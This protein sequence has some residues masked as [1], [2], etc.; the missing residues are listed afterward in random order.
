[1]AAWHGLLFREELRHSPYRSFTLL[2]LAGAVFL[3][4]P[5]AAWGVRE[6]LALAGEEG[7]DPADVSVLPL[8]YAVFLVWVLGAGLK[9]RT[10]W[11]VIR[12]SPVPRAVLGLDRA[13]GVFLVALIVAGPY[14]WGAVQG[15][16]FQPAAL[17][18]LIALPLWLSARLR[19][20]G[21]LW[22][23]FM[24]LLSA[25]MGWSM[26]FLVAK[27]LD[28][29][30]VFEDYNYEMARQLLRP[31]FARL[32]L[33]E[34]LL[35]ALRAPAAVHVLVGLGAL[36]G[37]AS[38]LGERSDDTNVFGFVGT[39]LARWR[40]A[41]AALAMSSLLR[42]LDVGLSQAVMAGAFALAARTYGLAA[43]PPG[44]V[45]W[46]AVAAL[47]WPVWKERPALPAALA[48]NAPDPRRV[49]VELVSGRHRAL[50]ATLVPFLLLPGAG[51]PLAVWVV[52]IWLLQYGSGWFAQLDP[53][54][55]PGLLVFALG[56]AVLWFGGLP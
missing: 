43:L 56:S 29:G 40:D 46:W 53:A 32:H 39:W 21:G 18:S 14:V 38:T 49:A 34:F 28:Q 13:L 11:W 51:A 50:A 36:W 10:L 44:L 47:W 25:A 24:L 19:G 6:V 54:W 41:P 22:Y 12:S 42:H 2:S 15:A 35:V 30:L 7:F 52:L 33:P 45:V 48:A 55:L 3:Y 9:G 5:F 37:L 4:F 8:A 1:M 16:D 26:A 23:P 17:L 31:V 20:A 27:Y